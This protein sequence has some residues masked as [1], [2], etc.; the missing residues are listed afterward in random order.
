MILKRLKYFGEEAGRTRTVLP[1]SRIGVGWTQDR[2]KKTEAEESFRA[3]QKAADEAFAEG[4]DDKHIVRAA[5]R[6]AGNKVLLGNIE[7]PVE[8]AVKYG[9]A[10]YLVSKFGKNAINYLQENGKLP[11]N[12]ATAF[13]NRVAPKMSKKAGLIGAGV[14]LAAAGAH[15]PK[16]LKKRK[17]AVLGAEI[18][19][20][21]RLKKLNKK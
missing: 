1:G 21:D 11:Y 20:K 10:A 4:K 2:N 8:D 14:A 5:K 3:G 13:A 7:D 9:G 12:K 18:N 6:A 16:I 17:S 19:T 15:L